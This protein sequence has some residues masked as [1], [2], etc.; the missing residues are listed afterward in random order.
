MSQVST[1]RVPEHVVEGSNAARR[2]QQTG[3][4]AVS[5]RSGIHVTTTLAASV[6][7]TQAVASTYPEPEVSPLQLAS[8]TRSPARPPLIPDLYIDKLVAY[9]P[10]KEGWMTRKTHKYVGVGNAYLVSDHEAHTV[11][12]PVV[13]LTIPESC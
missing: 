1:P 11:P 9:L 6:G 5:Q 3:P 7:V 13:R 10:A 8:T 12:D 2:S 4:L